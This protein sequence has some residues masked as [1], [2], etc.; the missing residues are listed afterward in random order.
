MNANMT[1][2]EAMR[3]LKDFNIT[4]LQA[5]QKDVMQMFRAINKDILKKAGA[6]PQLPNHSATP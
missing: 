4:T 1:V 5:S 3:M 6:L 2:S